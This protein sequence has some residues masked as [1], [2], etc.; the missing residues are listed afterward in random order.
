MLCKYILHFGFRMRS[1]LVR[2]PRQNW[3]EIHLIR[4]LRCFEHIQKIYDAKKSPLDAAA[5]TE[6]CFMGQS[7]CRVGPEAI[8]FCYSLYMKAT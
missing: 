6:R 3:G 7:C 4:V 8:Y 5:V 2:K 1:F